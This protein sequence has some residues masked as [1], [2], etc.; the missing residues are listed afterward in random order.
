MDHSA[1]QIFAAAMRERFPDADFARMLQRANLQ[2]ILACMR[3]TCVE[4]LI[5]HDISLFRDM[6]QRLSVTPAPAPDR[7]PTMT[8]D[9]RISLRR[10]VSVARETGLILYGRRQRSAGPSR[11]R[12]ARNLLN[13]DVPQICRLRA[14][15]D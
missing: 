9:Q 14:A 1:F 10:R 8:A 12:R 3:G 13:L 2:A 7:P 5:G 6:L 11:R 4:G 15:F